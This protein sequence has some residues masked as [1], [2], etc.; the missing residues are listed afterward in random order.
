ME[1]L[2][3]HAAVDLTNDGLELFARGA[4][5]REDAVEGF[6]HGVDAAVEEGGD[7]VF[8]AGK[9]EIDSAFGDPHLG[10]DVVYGGIVIALLK[11][12]AIGRLEDQLLAFEALPLFEA[13]VGRVQLGSVPD[14][15]ERLFELIA[16]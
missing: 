14:V 1:A 11:E 16:L 8:F 5:R 12:E 13:Q 3:I 4:V 10:G 9:V 6:E 15:F 7:E 2:T